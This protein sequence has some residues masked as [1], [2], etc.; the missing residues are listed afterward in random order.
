[1][2]AK[3]PIRKVF[4]T[5][6]VA[7]FAVVAV[8]AQEFRGSIIGRVTD[9]SGAAVANAKV[10]VTNTATNVA[11]V[12][13]T[14]EGGDYSVLFLT[15]GSYSLTVEARGFKRST[16]QNIEVRVADKIELEIRLEVGDVADNVNITADAP[17]VD[18]I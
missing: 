9:T 2:I 1:M 17:L 3:K 16:R 15:P 14:N 10:T 5:A 4:L 18:T 12:S 7:A 11:S 13:T 8:F 6:V